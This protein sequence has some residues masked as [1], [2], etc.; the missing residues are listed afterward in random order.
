[1]GLNFAYKDYACQN[2]LFVVLVQKNGLFSKLN[3]ANSPAGN[4]R[5]TINYSKE[6]I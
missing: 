6:G 4:P 5:F 2:F 3:Q 1:M